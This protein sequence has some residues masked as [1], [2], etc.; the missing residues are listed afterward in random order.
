[1][2]IT[3]EEPDPPGMKV[4]SRCGILKPHEEF[5]MFKRG[6]GRSLQRSSRCKD[7]MKIVVKEKYARKKGK[8]NGAS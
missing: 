8:E 6:R 2:K 5:T 4:C 7:C 3:Q 1:M